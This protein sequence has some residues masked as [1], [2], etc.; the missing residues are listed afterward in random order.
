MLNFDVDHFVGHN[1]VKAKIMLQ[2]LW[3]LMLRK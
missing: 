3:N 2:N 1:I